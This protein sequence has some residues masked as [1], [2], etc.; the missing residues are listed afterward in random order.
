MMKSPNQALAD[1]FYKV[2]I[3]KGYAVTFNLQD[4]VAYPFVYIGNTQTVN[5][6]V[7]LARTG[8]LIINID[9]WDTFKNRKRVSDY[10][11]VLYQI[12][13]QG[14]ETEDYSF[15][16]RPSASFDTL[17]VDNSTNTPLWRGQL[18][19]EFYFS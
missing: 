4:E 5:A 6:A 19:L 8:N 3:E 14:F 2:C 9:V 17:N 15:A 10:M 7:K 16:L 18:E 13:R 11:E 1:A 12:A